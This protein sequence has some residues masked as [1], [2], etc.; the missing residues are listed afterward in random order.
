MATFIR[1]LFPALTLVYE[2]RS[3]TMQHRVS[4][5]LICL[6][7]RTSILT[8]HLGDISAALAT[9]ASAGIAAIHLAGISAAKATKTTI[10]PFRSGLLRP[11][12]PAH[13]ESGTETT[14]RFREMPRTEKG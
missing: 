9:N 7:V 5:W 14:H 3:Q 4:V 8:E 13:Y 10:M 2:V 6:A 1:T 11:A 12:L